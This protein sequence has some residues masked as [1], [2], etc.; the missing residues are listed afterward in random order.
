[1][2]LQNR[3]PKL[4]RVYAR[5]PACKR[6]LKARAWLKQTTKQIVLGPLS[7]G[8]W[9]LEK[10][11]PHKCRWKDK[12]RLR[13]TI[14]SGRRTKEQGWCWGYSNKPWEILSDR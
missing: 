1:M 2:N 4:K 12:N 8:T 5:C 13:K 11:P 3:K 9:V 10:K 14:L 6:V 7:K